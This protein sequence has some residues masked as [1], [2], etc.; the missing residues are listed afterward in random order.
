MNTKL[1]KKSKRPE[2]LNFMIVSLMVAGVIIVES[3]L[4]AF[5]QIP[6]WAQ[7]GIALAHIPFT[8]I[9]ALLGWRA[10]KA[11]D[12]L[13]RLIHMQAFIISITVAGGIL[14]SYTLLISKGLISGEFIWYFWALLWVIYSLGYAYVTKKMS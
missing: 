9:V 6:V 1:K 2:T 12:E 8:I 3:A 5:D 14:I 7:Y 4:M 10:L 13:Q 11:L